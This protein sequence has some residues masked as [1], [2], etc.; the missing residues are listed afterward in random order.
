M[1]LGDLSKCLSAVNLSKFPT[2][3]SFKNIK[4]KAHREYHN[5]STWPKGSVS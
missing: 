5:E 3:R 1:K 2:F 4:V